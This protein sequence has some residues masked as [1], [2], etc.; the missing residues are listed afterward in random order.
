MSL[1]AEKA[2]IVAN[3]NGF[4]T[5]CLQYA[6]RVVAFYEPN[7]KTD[8]KNIEKVAR[9]YQQIAGAYRN[10]AQYEVALNWYQKA[11]TLIEPELKTFSE[12]VAKIYTEGTLIYTDITKTKILESVNMTD[13]TKKSEAIKSAETTN[14]QA[15]K[16]QQK[17]IKIF[18]KLNKN[19]TYLAL[20]YNN[21]ANLTPEVQFDKR[22]EY[23]EKALNLQIQ[24]T[25]KEHPDTASMYNNLALAALKANKT[26]V[27]LQYSE[28]SVLTL[29]QIYPAGHP[30]LVAGYL[31]RTRS[32][33]IAKQFVDA[34][35]VVQKAKEMAQRLLLE[36]HP[37]RV[38][39]EELYVKLNSWT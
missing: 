39:V 27:A 11:I 8:L 15:I 36:T 28:Q 33:E 34:Q 23:Y 38:R 25:G 31:N 22:L 4:Y 13:A 18:L 5:K 1:L 17:A 19:H 26:E 10:L 16:I 29:E 3:H 37:L 6:Q 12:S 32:L 30:N 24:L 20:C 7:L 21:L 14:V 2:C 9:M 35:I